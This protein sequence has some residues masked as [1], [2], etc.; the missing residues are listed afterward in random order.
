MPLKLLSYFTHPPLHITSHPNYKTRLNCK[1]C[2]TYLK[3]PLTY[4]IST[5]SYYPIPTRHMYR[6][7][8]LTL[9]DFFM[10][11]SPS[12]T[13]C[14]DNLQSMLSLC[15]TINAPVKSSEIEGPSTRI[16]FL[17][18]VINTALYKDASALL[19]GGLIGP[20]IGFKLTGC[21]IKL[22]KTLHGRSYLP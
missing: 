9:D 18:I 17:G 11:G 21:Q 4:I 12:S 3:H 15:T 6:L 2:I 13:E 1:F 22:E 7:S 19:V 16:T 14:A 8:L 20:V 5:G 10:A